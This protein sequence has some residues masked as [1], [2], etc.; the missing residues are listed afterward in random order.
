[1]ETLT[2]R[3]IVAAFLRDKG[4]DG[5]S[6]DY[7]CCDIADLMECESNCARCEPGYKVACDS[8]C[9]CDVPGYYEYHIVKERPA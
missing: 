3:D 7:C 9:D 8:D 1:M 6:C 5:L 2:V 4:Y